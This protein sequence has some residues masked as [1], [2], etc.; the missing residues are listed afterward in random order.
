MQAALLEDIDYLRQLID[1]EA[2]MHH[3]V[4]YPP[5]SLQRIFFGLRQ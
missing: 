3:K 2:D 1:E 4:T 5:V